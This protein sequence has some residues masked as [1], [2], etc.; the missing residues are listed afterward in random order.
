MQFVLVNTR[1]VQCNNRVETAYEYRSETGLTFEFHAHPTR[2]FEFVVTR[3]VE[4]PLMLQDAV[5]Q[6]W[7][8]RAMLRGD[9][10]FNEAIKTL[11][12]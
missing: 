4:L 6:A 2:S 8:S 9:T 10:P 12:V 5:I 7:I 11:E 1:E 3:G